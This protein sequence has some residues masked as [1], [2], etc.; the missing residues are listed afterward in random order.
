MKLSVAL[1]ERYCVLL[2]STLLLSACHPHDDNLSVGAAPWPTFEFLFLANDLG[3]LPENKYA[4]FE[5]PTSTSVIQAF[6]TGKLD[7]AL[8]SLDEV[9]TMVSLGIDLRIITV[10]DESTGGDALLVSPD[11]KTLEQLKGRTIGYENKA[12]GTLLLNEIFNVSSLTDRSLHLVEVKQNEALDVY[13]QDNI[14]G[15]IVREPEKQQLLHLGAHEL[16]NSNK[17]HNRITH[18]MIARADVLEEKEDSI[19]DL[20]T[21]FY[22]AH[23]YYLANETD[24]LATMSLRLPI[25]PYLLKESFKGTYFIEPK[26]ALMRLSGKPSN[27]E[28]QANKL[29]ELMLE[30]RMIAQ[31]TVN[32][33]SLISNQI[34][35]RVIYE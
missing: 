5:L 16:F 19:I 11:I 29:S 14:D 24:A 15:L 8:L 20:L 3:Y 27:I 33:E 2:F 12:A 9:L 17:L 18:L 25:F 23:H 35:Q 13:F 32:V 22:K 28:I 10:I 1:L 30:K 26:D 4:L 34:L 21:Q 7:V 31:K 6:Q